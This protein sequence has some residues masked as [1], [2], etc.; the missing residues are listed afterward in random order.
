MTYFLGVVSAVLMGAGFVLQQGVAQ[1]VSAKYFLRLR[2]LAR[3]V[4]YPRWLAGL[5]TMVAGQILAAWV[6]GHL[7]LSVAEPLLSA[8]L[9]FAL[10]LAWPL[11]GQPLTRS[12]VI[13]ALTLVAGVTALSLART[14][15][16]PELAFGS[17]ANW[18]PAAV[19]AG[20]V[21]WGFAVWG[22]RRTGDLR[23]IL[24]GVSAG[25]VFGLQDAVTRSAVQDLGAHGVAGLLVSW[26]AYVLFI[27][28]AAGI[29][30]MES[31]FS[32]APL[33][34]SLPAITAGE[35]LVGIGLGIV[36]FGDRL[37]TSVGV[38]AVQVVG[39]AALV[40]GVVL[41]A[42]GPALASVRAR[43]RAMAAR[44]VADAPGGRGWEPTDSQSC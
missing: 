13:G 27:V 3:L 33:H 29:W 8:N 32:A 16:S 11:S 38:I 35:P 25:V 6:I 17:S 4:R 1:Q 20:L 7:V 10:L 31:A 28:G 30:L 37:S 44:E 42:R 23:A 19:A 21:A 40:A 39:L 2:L 15:R 24:T 14:I 18:R 26:P 34:A 22:R 43:A 5:V 9:L 41:V 36:V 12:E